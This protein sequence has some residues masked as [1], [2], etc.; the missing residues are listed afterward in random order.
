MTWTFWRRA[1]RNRDLDEELQT[2]L[3]LAEREALE[4]GCTANQARVAARRELGNLNLVEEATRDTWGGRWLSDLLQD[5]RI[6]ARMLRR[7]PGFSILAI[8]CLIL[9]IGANAAVFSWIE[10]VLFRPYPLVAHQDR[11]T[12]I[13]NTSRGSADPD[14]LSWPDFQ[15]LEKRSTLA[16]AFI[17]EKL[18]SATL[19]I[20]DRSER[21]LGSVVSGNY[22][23]AL[24]LHMALGRGFRP[25]E[26]R[27]RN[28]HPVA[29]ISYQFWQERYGGD[30]AII[31]KM[32][33]L[34]RVPHTIVGVAPEG[35]FGT[36]VGYSFNFW[37]P[38]SMQQTFD[39]GGSYKLEDRG[40]RWIEGFVLRKPGVTRSQLQQELSAIATRLEAEYPE[41][42]RGRGVRI[43]P[44]WETPFNAANTL[45]A[46]L[47]IALCV[48]VFVLL[49]ACAN[50]GNLLLVRAFNRR[51]EMTVRLAL[52]AARTRLFKQV[53]TEGLILSGLAAFGGVLVAWW[54]RN[55]LVRL[56]PPRGT[57]LRIAGEL[58]WRVFAITAGVCVLST[59]LFALV[60]AMQSSRAE[61]T[62]AL[63]SESASVV[64]GRRKAWLRSVLVVVQVSLSFLLLVGAGLVLQSL[65]RLRSASPGFAADRVVITSLG[66]SAAGYD[67][68]RARTFEDELMTRVVALPGV[69][70]ASF[71]RLAPFSLPSYSSAR[72]AV[73][74]YQPPRDQQPSA[75]YI[76]VSPGYFA[77]LGIPLV[78]GRDFARSDDESAPPVA[79]VNEVMVERY[80][81]GADPVGQRLQVNGKWMQVVGVAKLSKYRS[82]METPQPF[83]YVP[84]R[85]NFSMLAALEVR[86]SQPPQT[87]SALL[88]REVHALDRE[89]PF[90]EAIPLRTQVERSMAAPRVA[91]TLLTVF[92][93][94]A[95]A[96]ASIGLYA[97]MSYAVSQGT[98]EFGLRMA[99][100]ARASDLLR[101][102]VSQGLLLTTCG[103]LLGAGAALILTRLLGYLLYEV[104]PRDPFAFG[105]SFAIMTVVGVVASILPAW[106][107]TRIDPVRALQG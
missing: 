87:I 9:G 91:V 16:Q 32:Q 104:S 83:F 102:V 8:L 105:A 74:G 76:E 18:A 55:L 44:L 21:A 53:L 34:N 50:V 100:G 17:A 31:G 56:L 52:G 57:P 11:L 70:S 93:G 51:H 94:L 5:L 15:D 80:W 84:L 98:R 6:G 92:G 64:G 23:D 69:E 49:I 36:F 75:E 33:V 48:T 101:L 66:F 63:R 27:G 96:L 24:G 77:T 3:Q 89:L 4:T 58:D 78:S 107:A 59:L 7:S 37:V 14:D 82:F 45:G 73:D 86:T 68:T 2:H 41:T 43:Y 19:S 1:R 28:A 90:Y 67:A 79:I 29:V 65:Q 26:N 81:Q 40:A 10:G 47:G 71:S 20:G 106:R 62:E 38:V 22:F 12:A 42:N 61:I 88:V 39:Y 103:V 54:S 30:P 97:V 72:I 35:F 85:Q 99:L 25:E 60:P 46:T 13:V 95:L